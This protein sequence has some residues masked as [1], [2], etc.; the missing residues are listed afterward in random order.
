MGL[1][2]VVFVRFDRFCVKFQSLSQKITDLTYKNDIKIKI[3]KRYTQLLILWEKSPCIPFFAC[4]KLTSSIIIDCDEQS[5]MINT[6]Q[7]F[8]LVK[9]S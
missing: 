9:T 8:L 4:L 5:I 7:F 6:K 1:I 2:C 3:I